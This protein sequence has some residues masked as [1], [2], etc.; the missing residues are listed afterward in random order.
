MRFASAKLAF[1]FESTSIFDKKFAC[2]QLLQ[3]FAPGGV[4]DRLSLQGIPT[5]CFQLE[6]IPVAGYKL[7]AVFRLLYSSDD[8]HIR[9]LLDL[10][11]IG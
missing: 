10:F 5:L 4:K 9:Y 7:A 3:S 11:I 1:S 2:I 8:V 6:L